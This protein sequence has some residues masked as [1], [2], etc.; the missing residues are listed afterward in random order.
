MKLT[1]LKRIMLLMVFASLAGNI[2][3]A[4]EQGVL[5]KAERGIKKGGEAA[6]Q[7]IEKGADAT[8]KGLKNGGEATLK[9][10]KKAG[11]WVDKK[12]DKVF[13]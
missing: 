13:K 2:A 12:L 11:N 3:F 1:A 7:G 9:G 4:E 5:D 8:G 10:V 6:G